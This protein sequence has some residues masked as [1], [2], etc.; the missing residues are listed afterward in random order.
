MILIEWICNIFS[1][2]TREQTDDVE[3]K[4]KDNERHIIFDLENN[5][6]SGGSVVVSGD[7]VNLK[8]SFEDVDLGGSD[9][10]GEG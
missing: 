6:Y 9:N 4:P 10:Q 7:P 5:K 8:S 3:K 2:C 1:S